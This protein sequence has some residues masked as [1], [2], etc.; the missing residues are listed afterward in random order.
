MDVGKV[1]LGCLF[2]EGRVPGDAGLFDAD[3]RHEV[4]DDQQP[5]VRGEGEQQ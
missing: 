2:V 4:G 5:G 1:V 3:A